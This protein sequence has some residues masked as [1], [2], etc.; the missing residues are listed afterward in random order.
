MKPRRLL[1]SLSCLL[2]L[3]LAT[4]CVSWDPLFRGSLTLFGWFERLV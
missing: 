4:G 1:V 2:L 3:T